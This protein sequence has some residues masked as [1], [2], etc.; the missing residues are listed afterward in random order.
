MSRSTA[1]RSA[2]GFTASGSAIKKTL[3]AAEQD[4]LDVAVARRLWR[5]RQ[6]H[7][8]PGR[9]IFIDET[10]ANTKMVRLRGR[11]PRG[12][13]LM[14]QVPHGHWKTMTFLAGLRHDRIIAPFV[15]DGAM[16][17][18]IFLTYA[19]DVLA[20][21]LEPGDIVIMDNLSSHKS[22]AVHDAITAHDAELRFLPPYSPDLNPIEQVFARLKALLRKA[23]ERTVDALWDRIGQL[24]QN[25]PAVECQYYF[26]NAGYV[27]T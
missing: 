11:A 24:L 22:Q 9:L 13:R 26:A 19:R 27:Q 23:E 5:I 15:I 12:Q 2:A 6:P 7:L 14:A 8:D 20:P 10:G 25:F 4:R 16:N 3:R 18:E 21:K 17:G 1:R